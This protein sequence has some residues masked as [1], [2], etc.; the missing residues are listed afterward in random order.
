MLNSFKGI[1]AIKAVN[2]IDM[3]G[4]KALDDFTFQVRLRSPIAHWI[5]MPTYWVTFPLREDIVKKHGNGW[6]K[7]GKI[8]RAH[9]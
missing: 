3:I 4:I 1:K 6:T 5:M 9:V 7:P 2:G 8:G